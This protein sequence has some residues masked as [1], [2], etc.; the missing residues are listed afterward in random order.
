MHKKMP[1]HPK[2]TLCCHDDLLPIGAI[3]LL[4]SSSKTPLV[5]SVLFQKWDF[6]NVS[7]A[8]AN[9]FTGPGA[10]N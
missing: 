7:V 3:D 9:I 2:T 10:F 8:E 6:Q 1:S 5:M 4:G